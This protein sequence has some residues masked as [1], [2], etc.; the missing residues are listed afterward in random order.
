MESEY[1]ELDSRERKRPGSEPRFARLRQF[2]A[3][4]LALSSLSLSACHK[5]EEKAGSEQ[6]KVVLTSPQAKD[7]VLTQQYVCQIHSRRHIN[8]CALEGGYLQEIRINEGQAVTKGDLMFKIVP[9]IF[10]AK[11]DAE[12]A[13]AKLAEIEKATQSQTPGL[14]RINLRY[15]GTEPLFRIMLESDGT[16]SE[17]DLAQIALK[18][19]SEVQSE[20]EQKEKAVDILSCGCG[21]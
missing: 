15:S 21:L 11:L 19:C 4:T 7:I 6:S 3:M 5:H 10:Q 14:I 16:Q 1:A 9:I 12:L 20:R 8:I 18:L 13:E 17:K 2:V